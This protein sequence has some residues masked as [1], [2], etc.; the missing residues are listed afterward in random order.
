MRN[1]SAALLAGYG[2]ECRHLL[3][4]RRAAIG[5]DILTGKVSDE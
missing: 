5:G 3:S 2:G 4:W 1:E